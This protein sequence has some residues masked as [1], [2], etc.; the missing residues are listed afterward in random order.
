MNLFFKIFYSLI[1]LIL[2]GIITVSINYCRGVASVC[3]WVEKGGAQP[4]SISLTS[5]PTGR[6]IEI[7]R[8]ELIAELSR[9]VQHPSTEHTKIEPKK[10]HTACGPYDGK[11]YFG[12]LRSASFSIT[13]FAMGHKGFFAYPCK[14]DPFE[15][16]GNII[17][18]QSE[19]TISHELWSQLESDYEAK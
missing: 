17:I 3:A 6:Q 5:V 11:A 1:C 14:F 9:E 18:A 16:W 15:D 13:V 12:P 10:S 7:T 4:K 8:G 2:L 19:N